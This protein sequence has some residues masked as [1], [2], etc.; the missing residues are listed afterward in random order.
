LRLL[1]ADAGAVGG[2]LE[3]LAHLPRSLK[4]T[5]VNAR[6]QAALQAAVKAPAAWGAGTV[7]PARPMDLLVLL[8][9]AQPR[10]M[11][12]KMVA[13]WGVAMCLAQSPSR[14]TTTEARAQTRPR[15]H[16]ENPAICFE[17]PML[18]IHFHGRRRQPPVSANLRGQGAGTQEHQ[19]SRAGNP[20]LE[21]GGHPIWGKIPP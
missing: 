15:T 21:L 11:A 19:R 18:P 4:P 8:G 3:R 2:W 7:C 12:R 6:E 1:H 20:A 17:S 5:M 13:Q 14:A 16:I 9:W 10:Q